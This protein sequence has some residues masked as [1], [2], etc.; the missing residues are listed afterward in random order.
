[1]IDP[2]KRKAIYHL[3]NEGMGLREISRRLG[4]SRNTVRAI[5]DLKGNIPDLPR[6]DKRQIDPEL[7]RRLYDECNGWVQRIHEKLS[8]QEEIEVGYSTLTSMIRELDLGQSRKRRCDRVPDEPGAEMQHDTSPYTLKIGGKQARVVASLLYFRY[9]KIRYLKF[10]RSF[11]RFK[12]K[13]FLHEALT[14]W[15]YTARISIIDNTNLARLRGSGKNAVMTPEMEG[16]ARQYGFEFVCHEIRHSN[17]KAGNERSFFTIET[18]FFP[19]RTFQTLEDLNRQAFEW[20]TVR[21]ANRAVSKTRLIPL[22]A[23]GHE[24]SYLSKVPPYV[25]PP[26]LAHKRGTDQYGYAPLDGNF[27]WVPGTSRVDVKLL[28]YSN[29][30]KIYHKRKLL[31]EYDLPADG[32]KNE[33]FSPKGQPKPQY[34]PKDRK[35]PTEG[36]ERKLRSLS[37]EVEAYLSFVLKQKGIQKHRF[38]RQLYGLYQKIVLPLFIKTIN[39]ALK[40]HITDIQTLERIAILQLKEGNYEVPFVETNEDFQDRASYLEGRLTDEVDLSGYDNMMEDEDG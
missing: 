10:Y 31:I 26:Y 20:A 30:L 5:I 7:L 28:E 16:F 18:N 33:L 23:F 11:N 29:C 40:Y 14:F 15:G 9:S 35:K 21:M 32:V 24:K 4:V 37:E 34:Q 25:P 12:M 38:I 13:C 36:E 6:K 22:K 17:R 19:G 8:E 1:M 39:R 27:Y 3:H 2:D